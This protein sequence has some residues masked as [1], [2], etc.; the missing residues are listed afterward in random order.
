MNIITQNVK[1]LTGL[2]VGAGV[3]YMVMPSISGR[4]QYLFTGYGKT[5]F[6]HIGPSSVVYQTHKVQVGVS[7][8]LEQKVL[9]A[10]NG[11]NLNRFT[12]PSHNICF[13]L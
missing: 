13:N 11:I 7:V 2:T 8:S 1:S 6:Y 9:K 12:F 4:V 5:S 10:V 3:E